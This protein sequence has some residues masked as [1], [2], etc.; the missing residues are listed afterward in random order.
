MVRLR[1]RKRF[2]TGGDKD[3]DPSPAREETGSGGSEDRPQV[4]FRRTPAIRGD[5]V[6]S[7][8]VIWL[9]VLLVLVLT[10]IVTLA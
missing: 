5:R 9:A 7:R 2:Q 8:S 10:A 6:P 1:Q 4:Q 3:E